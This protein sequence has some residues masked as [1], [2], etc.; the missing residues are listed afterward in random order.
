MI[1]P[2]VVTSSPCWAPPALEEPHVFCPLPLIS[3]QIGHLASTELSGR[4]CL[5]R[6]KFYFAQ[7]NKSQWGFAYERNLLL[8]SGRWRGGPSEVWRIEHILDVAG[9][10]RAT[11]EK[12][13]LHRDLCEVDQTPTRVPLGAWCL[14][15]GLGL[16]CPAPWLDH[17]LSYLTGQIH[18]GPQKM[19][20]HT[21][22]RAT[23]QA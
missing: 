20:M 2:L 12:P 19:T 16:G 14:F 15:E 7:S 9:T 23:V 11:G 18:L 6:S 22:P 8:F 17:R 5:F 10:D 4:F 21:S 1:S 3:F 13:A